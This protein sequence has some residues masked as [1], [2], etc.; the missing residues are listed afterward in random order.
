[1]RG[2]EAGDRDVRTRP[3]AGRRAGPRRAG[4]RR[5]DR[6]ARRSSSA[7]ARSWTRRGG[8]CSRTS[9][10]T[11]ERRWPRCGRRSRRWP[12]AWRPSP[13]RYLRAMQRDVEALSALVDD[14]F[15]LARIEG[16]RLDLRAIAARPGR[17]RR[18]GGRGAGPADG[19]AHGRRHPHRRR[20]PGAGRRQRR[21]R[22]AG[23]SATSSTTPSTTRPPDRRC[24]IAVA[25]DA[26]GPR[27]ASSTT[28][29]GFPRRLRRPRLRSVRPRRPEP[30][31]SHGGAGL[32]LAIAHG[33]VE[34]H[35]GRIW[36]E[37]PPGGHVAFESCPPADPTTTHPSV[38]RRRMFPAGRPLRKHSDGRCPG[39]SRWCR[40]QDQVAGAVGLL[41]LG[42]RPVA[43]RELDADARSRASPAGR[44]REPVEPLPALDRPRADPERRVMSPPKTIGNQNW[45]RRYEATPSV[46]DW[47]VRPNPTS[48]GM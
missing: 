28:G 26:D 15:L 35:G 48:V 40:R 22:S 16:G 41:T 31:P 10:T 45:A 11:C 33:L 37:P 30:Q 20:R 6:A 36:I 39:A 24:A 32:G 27:C 4:A 21:R 3:A 14:L 8:R 1:M 25:G 7:S 34:A 38:R 18:R 47:R 23:S 46:A 29:P 12:T 44:C 2:I 19:G 42:P 17:A 9:A 13:E 43:Q 5:A